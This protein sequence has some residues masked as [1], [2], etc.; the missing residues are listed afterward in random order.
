MSHASD[1]RL[2]RVAVILLVTFLGG[3]DSGRAAIAAAHPAE[4][5]GADTGALLARTAETQVVCIAPRGLGGSSPS[6][7]VSL[8]QL[9]DDLEAARLQLNRT[10][11]VFWGMSGGGWLARRAR[12]RATAPARRP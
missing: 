4:A 10:P 12:A 9:V 5:F 2:V 3:A 6:D 1:R 11:W 7:H 8:E